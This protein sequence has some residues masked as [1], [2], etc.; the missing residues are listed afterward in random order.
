[1]NSIGIA[2]AG[3]IEPKEILGGGY[4]FTSSSS[5]SSYADVDE[6]AYSNTSSSR[7]KGSSSILEP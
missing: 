2:P 1:L 7:T 3:E 6:E 5:S 4:S